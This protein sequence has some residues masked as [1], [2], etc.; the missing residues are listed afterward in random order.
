MTILKSKPSQME[1]YPIITALFCGCLLISNIL[2]SKTFSLYDII[3]PCG[4]VIFPIV[5]IVGD[6]LTEIYGFT[7]AK[8]TIYLGFIINVIAIVAYQIAIFLPGTDIASSNAFSI[9]LGSTPR[10]LLASFISYLVGSYVNA[11]FMKVLKERYTDYL[12]A[13]CSISTLFGEGLDAILFISI[14]F[15]GTMPNDVIITMIICQGAFKILYEIIVYPITRAVIN[16][17]K[18]LDDAPFAKIA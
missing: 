10:I 13:R 12:F 3:L 18:S 7:L 14:A 6:V 1:L 11:Y 15:A 9:I 2:A 16:W 4:V 17:M 8:R 5:Y